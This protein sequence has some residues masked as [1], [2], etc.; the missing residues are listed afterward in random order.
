VTRVVRR[1]ARRDAGTRAARACAV[2]ALVVA[3]TTEREPPGAGPPLAPAA[4]VERIGMHDGGVLAV[5]ALADGRVLS[6]GA[7]RVVR[8]W[9]GEGAEV[10]SIDA[11]GASA[12]A[13]L[14]AAGDGRVALLPAT[15]G[16]LVWDANARAEATRLAGAV[17]P[18]RIAIA[19]D[20]R[21]AAAASADGELTIWPLPE[22]AP[23]VRL[24]P[25]AGRVVGLAVTADSTG[26][27]LLSAGDDDRLCTTTLA[28]RRS[29][30][31]DAP[32]EGVSVVA[33]TP[34]G[35]RAASGNRVG[36]VRL[37]E[38]ATGRALGT[39][40][41]HDGEVTALAFTPDGARL[42]TGGADRVATLLDAHSGRVLRRLLAPGSY[43]SAVAVADDGHAAIVG[44]DDGSVLRWRLP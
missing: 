34:D 18:S 29:R 22:G 7:D 27:V 12:S 31:V 24:R 16:V 15:A 6:S 25:H 21:A 41:A 5:A 1:V 38:A 19:P 10:G 23:S 33:F 28:D 17:E 11:P 2:G 37:W 44:T 36:E 8:V 20:A 4:G 9:D 39:F 13:A 26:P 30:C 32:G 43:V 3:C 35:R 40:V 42:V 14:A